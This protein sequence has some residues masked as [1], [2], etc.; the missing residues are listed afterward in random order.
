VHNADNEL[1]TSENDKCNN[2]IS[3]DILIQAP[4]KKRL[5]FLDLLL[6]MEEKSEISSQDVHDE[7]T[8]FM[9]E[10]HY[11][12]T[13][14][15]T[16]TQGH[17][18]TTASM[19]WTLFLLGLD[20]KWQRRVHEELDEIFQ[21]DNDRAPTYDDLNNM[22]ILE[23]CIKEALRLYPSVPIIGRLIESDVVLSK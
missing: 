21:G 23:Y 4:T 7:V 19:N 3:N 14:P 6:E 5:A 8:T 13:H 15:H 1:N 20:T 10:V 17:D 16:Q 18:T 9:F 11:K 2:Y 12:H 22:R